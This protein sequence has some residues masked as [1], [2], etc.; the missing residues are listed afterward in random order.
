ME[1][2]DVCSTS[3]ESLFTKDDPPPEFLLVNLFCIYSHDVIYSY[4]YLSF[5]L[6]NGGLA[7][8]LAR[9]Y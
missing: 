9:C 3:G 2:P 1:A 7:Y 5:V 6:G 4:A 8:C